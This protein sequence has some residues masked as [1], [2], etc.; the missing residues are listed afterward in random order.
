MVLTRKGRSK[1][2][3]KSFGARRVLALTD[4]ESS[5]AQKGVEETQEPGGVE[6]VSG[7]LAEETGNE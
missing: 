7:L 5:G 3:K 1:K 6:S 2:A 4:G